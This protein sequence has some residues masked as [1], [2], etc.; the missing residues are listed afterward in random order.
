MANPVTAI[1]NPKGDRLMLY[2]VDQHQRLAL[3][4]IPLDTTKHNL[5]YSSNGTPA[6][7]EVTNQSIAAVYLRGLPIVFGKIVTK[8]DKLVLGQ[9]SPIK[10]ILAS[11]EDELDATT[12]DLPALAAVSDAEDTAWFYY[13]KRPVPQAPAV[14]M[15]AQLNYDN[16][17]INPVQILTPGSM[18]A[19]TSRLAALYVDKD[20]REVFF[21][22]QGSDKQIYC[23][24]VGSHLEPQHIAG[25]NLAMKGTSIA[26]TKTESGTVYLYYLSEMGDIQRAT[27]SGGA[28]TTSAGTMT[29]FPSLAA[30]RETQLAVFSTKNNETPQNNLFYINAGETRYKLN[31]DKGGVV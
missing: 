23:L 11:N 26:V 4:Q 13:L 29:Q 5:L 19:E 14:L 1:P 16:L 6:G 7:S 31:V 10:N 17:D 21:Q 27:R 22:K 25:T 2:W 3:S 20:H 30:Q 15:E 9:I 18:P 8:S 12:F 24:V 28:W